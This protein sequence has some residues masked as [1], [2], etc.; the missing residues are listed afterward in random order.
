MKMAKA[1]LCFFLSA[2]I[3]LGCTCAIAESDPFRYEGP[4]FDTPEEAVLYYLAGLKNQ[5]FEQMLD[6]FAWETQAEHFDYKSLITRVKGADPVLIPGMPFSCNL[7]RSANLEQLRGA[8]SDYISRALQCYINDE[9]YQS[10][11]QSLLIRQ[12]D[13]IDAYFGRC[14]N[15]RA[16]QLTAMSNIRIYTPDDLTDGKF[17]LGKNPENYLKMNARYGADE[18]R[19]I[20]VVSDV[21][22]QSLAVSPTVARYGDRWYLVS[23]SSM[24][25][26]ILGIN[27]DTQA[28]YILPDDISARLETITPAAQVSALPEKNHHA[29]RYEGDGFDTPEEAVACYLNGLKSGNMQQVLSAF[30][31]ETQNEHYSL[32]DYMLRMKSVSLSSPVKMPG[33]NELVASSNLCS[34]RYDQSRKIYRSVRSFVLKNTDGPAA[35]LLKGRRVNLTNEEEI[36]DFIGAFDRGYDQKLAQ[37]GEIFYINPVVVIPKYTSDTNLKLLGQYQKIYG[38]DELY[39]ILALVDLGGEL[40]VADPILARY[41]EKWYV[42]SVPGL[43][44]NMLNVSADFM[45]F[46]SL[47]GTMDSVLG[48]F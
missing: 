31:W 3:V 7:L 11:T 44:F 12:E 38:A 20:V 24:T 47:E 32:K 28:F 19:D 45:G 16:E 5:D 46:V 39:E 15:G 2:A 30:A 9:L 33:T 4:G 13:D 18:T 36:D 37:M 21:G 42:V 48:M 23:V 10:Q 17:S 29:F 26:M 25:S 34:L 43:A 1:F 27:V 8:Q 35:E 6:A 22:S 41:G 14:D 40:L